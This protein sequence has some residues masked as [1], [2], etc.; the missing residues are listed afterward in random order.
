[1]P[2]TYKYITDDKISVI[3]NK[4]YESV[5]L[6]G[7]IISGTYADNNVINYSHDR[8][9]SVYDYPYLSSSANPIFDITVG[10]SNNST[11]SSSANVKNAEK[12]MNYTEFAQVLMG[13]DVTG[14]INLFDEDG[15]IVAGGT[16][17]KEC[18]FLAF[19]R[20]TVKDGIKRGSFTATF[21]TGGSFTS[22]SGREEINDAHAISSYFVNSPT[23]EWSYLSGS[24]KGTV[25]LIFYG[26]GVVVLT[27]SLFTSTVASNQ[28]PVFF[29][30][31]ALQDQ[32]VNQAFTGSPISASANGLRRRVVNIGFVNTT[33]LN[34]TIYHLDIGTNE[35][36]Y[37]S[38]PTYLSAS[39]IRVKNDPSDN[40]VSYITEIGLY[41]ADNELLASGKIS[42]PIR[43][44][45]GAPLSIKCRTDY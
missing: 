21:F 37:S 19:S 32:T 10:Y 15:N 42:E 13:Y 31:S 9:Q 38:N 39:K 11:M 40:P 33:E 6:T 35:F 44:N 20:L 12:I 28:K 1:M 7:T 8:F 16:K 18:I 22:Y 4:L 26:V 27:A 14:S 30:S 5:P 3:S 2:S 36:N 34:S 24:T 29:S 25:G 41:S 45:N 23:G 17:L 43:K